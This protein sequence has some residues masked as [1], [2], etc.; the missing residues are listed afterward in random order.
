MFLC[1][2]Q[3]NLIISIQTHVCAPLK[4]CWSDGFQTIQQQ[5]RHSRGNGCLPPRPTPS[6]HNYCLSPLLSAKGRVPRPPQLN[7]GT[8]LASYWCYLV[9]LASAIASCYINNTRVPTG[10]LG[11]CQLVWF[12]E[13]EILCGLGWHGTPDSP[14]SVSAVLGGQVSINFPSTNAC[15][16][17]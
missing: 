15:V 4:H 11:V 14:A 17:R 8:A 1:G 5:H 3:V 7:R 16:F 9:S 2:I 12:S 13:A 6:W 10:R